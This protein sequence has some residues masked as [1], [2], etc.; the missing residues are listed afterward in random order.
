LRKFNRYGKEKIKSV[1]PSSN[2]VPGCEKLAWPEYYVF[3]IFHIH[4]IDTLRQRMLVVLPIDAAHA[5]RHYVR[6][7]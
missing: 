6:T 3:P 4:I 2:L 7:V 1:L 5:V